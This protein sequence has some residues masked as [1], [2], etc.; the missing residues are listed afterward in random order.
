MI[1]YRIPGP[2]EILPATEPGFGERLE[3]YRARRPE[4]SV[5]TFHATAPARWARKPSHS[6]P[7][8]T[9]ATPGDRDA[10][11]MVVLQ[12]TTWCN[13]DC[14][15]CY[16]PDR[17]VNKSMTPD[18]V[19]AIARY[20]FARP[21]ADPLDVVWQSGE[22][23]AVGTAFYERAIGI[24]DAAKPR[25]HD[26]VHWIQT[27]GTLIDDAWCDLFLRHRVQVGVSI[28]GSRALH[29]AQRSDRNGAGSFD[30]TMAGVA[31]LRARAVP[32]SVTTVLTARVMEHVEPVWQF[33]L[34]QGIRNV[35][36]LTEEP[37]G[38]HGSSLLGPDPRAVTQRYRSF[39]RKLVALRAATPE[40]R[41]REL[42]QACQYI[43][44][45]GMP[46]CSMESE[47]FAILSFD[48]EGNVGTFSPELLGSH[49]ASRGDFVFDNVHTPNPGGAES[50]TA[51]QAVC[52]EVRA[53]V[54]RCAAS[55]EYFEVCGGG[56]PVNKLRENAS[57]DSAETMTC[58]LRIKDT[59][60][61][62]LEA[63]ENQA[64]VAPILAKAAL[65]SN[66]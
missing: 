63:L 52:D 49:H 32:F 27:N 9:A 50:A 51:F 43:R 66:A 8:A 25:G 17:D 28:D 37:S 62:V 65:E 12:P 58:R 7:V 13:L 20:V 30:R 42:D 3:K 46:I 44:D 41:V 64:Y 18:T 53:G 39:L 45:G 1:E 10:T 40:I 26:I 36:L 56:M 34:E 2:P 47:P 31:K 16:L 54:E 14:A 55:C 21:V 4:A 24:I 6:F 61:I 22:P 33:Y 5:S 57:F 60:D 23:L 38:L 35:V 59:F 15:Y 48:C 29:D 11:R 19:T